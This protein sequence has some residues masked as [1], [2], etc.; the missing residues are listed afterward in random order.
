LNHLANLDYQMKTGA[1]DKVL[2][3]ELFLLR[4]GA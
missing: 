2:G 4:L 3:I 1:V